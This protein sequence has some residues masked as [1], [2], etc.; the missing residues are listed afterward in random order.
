MKIDLFCYRMPS[1]FLTSIYGTL[2]GSLF[3]LNFSSLLSSALTSKEILRT[4]NSFHCK[5]FS[6]INLLKYFEH[7][8][9]PFISF[10][11]AIFVNLALELG[12]FL[13]YYI[14]FDIDVPCGSFT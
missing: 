12:E 5:T 11:F 14:D 7:H 6:A 13:E 8:G 2:I 3:S 9:V 10:I 1:A 4:L